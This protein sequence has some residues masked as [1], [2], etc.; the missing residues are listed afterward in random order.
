M[1]ERTTTPSNWR[2]RPRT[3]AGEPLTG[4][5]GNFATST[6][7]R[8]TGNRSWKNTPGKK[9]ATLFRKI[10]DAE[11]KHGRVRNGRSGGGQPRKVGLT[12]TLSKLLRDRLFRPGSTWGSL[13]WMNTTT[14]ERVGSIS[15]EAH[16]GQKS[17]RVRLKYTT[18]RWDGKRRKSDYWIQLET[19]PQPF[20]GRRWWFVC[21][22]RG[23]TRNRVVTS[24]GAAMQLTRPKRGQRHDCDDAFRPVPFF[25]LWRGEEA[26]A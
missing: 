17:G 11:R 6:R 21:P 24:A 26:R 7:P 8:A 5:H 3:P 20:G 16:L 2:S 10:L 13:G 15:Y 4:A 12:L 19:T 9:L 23:N 22:R 18:T 14:G 25:V 1:L